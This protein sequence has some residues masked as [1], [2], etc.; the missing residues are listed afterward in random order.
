MLGPPREPAGQLLLY[1]GFRREEIWKAQR[2]KPVFAG[3]KRLRVEAAGHLNQFV[4][5]QFA[6]FCEAVGFVSK[7]GVATRHDN[8]P[9]LQPFLRRVKFW[10][11]RIEGTAEWVAALS[12]DWI[13]DISSL[14]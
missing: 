14:R 3:R 12:R 9:S 6:V 4:V 5:R 10:V 11:G 7:S 2:H 13:V 8:P 1:V